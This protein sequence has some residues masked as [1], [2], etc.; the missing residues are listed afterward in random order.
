MRICNSLIVFEGP[1]FSSV[2]GLLSGFD[3]LEK[4]SFS[5]V[6]RD[7][8][9]PSLLICANPQPFATEDAKTWMAFGIQASNALPPNKEIH[10]IRKPSID[11][12]PYI[13][14]MRIEVVTNENYK[15]KK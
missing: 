4:M 5:F 6:I 11:V 8:S 13:D 3:D 7:P 10:G 2:F 14:T 9:S 15:I 12:F 1:C